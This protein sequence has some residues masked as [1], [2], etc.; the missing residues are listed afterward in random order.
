MQMLNTNAVTCSREPPEGPLL[1]SVGTIQLPFFIDVPFLLQLPR[2]CAPLLA[3]GKVLPPTRYCLTQAG[4]SGGKSF[5]QPRGGRGGQ[6]GRV[7]GAPG[8]GGRGV[9]KGELSFDL[10][11]L[12]SLPIHTRCLLPSARP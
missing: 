4:T 7:P 12:A 1:A 5:S 9:A 2:V 10:S 6:E 11:S 8:P 3:S